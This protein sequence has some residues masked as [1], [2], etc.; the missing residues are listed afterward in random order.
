MGAGPP[1]DVCGSCRLLFRP[2]F[3]ADGC[4]PICRSGLQRSTDAVEVREFEIGSRLRA[5]PGFDR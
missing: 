1:V 4:C 2:G 3:A 5:W